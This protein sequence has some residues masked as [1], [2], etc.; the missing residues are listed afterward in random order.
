M[1]QLFIVLFLILTLFGCRQNII[2]KP[3]NLISERQME[4]IMYDLM[5]LDAI[6]ST[7]YTYMEQQKAN[8]TQLIYEKYAIDSLQ[9]AESMVYYA[10]IPKVYNRMMNSVE[11]RLKENKKQFSSEKDS[12]SGDMKKIRKENAELIQE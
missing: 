7:D 3:E 4:K 2:P 10:S 5:L 1:K 12:L 8:F 6:K 9:L 11:Q